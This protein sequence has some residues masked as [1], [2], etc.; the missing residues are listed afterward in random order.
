MEEI[1]YGL[2]KNSRIIET[3]S[4]TYGK[5]VD[6]FNS[7]ESSPRVECFN[8]K[9]DIDEICLKFAEGTGKQ[10][11]RT[12][13][14]GFP[15]TLISDTKQSEI[16]RLRNDGL[17]LR[18]IA[19]K[20]GFLTV[21]TV[22]DHLNNFEERKRFYNMWV[23]WWNEAEIIAKAIPF[24]NVAKDIFSDKKIEYCNQ[25]GIKTVAD[26]IVMAVENPVRDMQIKLKDTSGEYKERRK[27][28]FENIKNNL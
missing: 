8:K 25:I 13:R 28:I 26:Y 10:F 15:E 9:A 14:K 24:S 4:G 3:F 18:D 16:A 27:K 19:G 6:Y 22:V 20:M 1:W 5:A 2:D 11:A 12:K 7:E 17:S 23:T 21:K